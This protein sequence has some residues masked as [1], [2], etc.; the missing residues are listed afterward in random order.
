MDQA[1]EVVVEMTEGILAGI[2][3]DLADVAPEEADWRPLPEANSIGLIVRHLAIE[4]Q[5]HRACLERGEPMPHELTDEI[6]HQIDSVPLDF[7]QNRAMFEQALESFLARLRDTTLAG[8][9]ERSREAYG[10]RLRSPHVL[11]FHQALH[12]CMH[13]GQIRT[14]RNLYEKT[15]GRPARYFP[16]NPT[17]PRAG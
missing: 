8:L 15:R 12:V 16:E 3:E 4:A 9:A 10:E 13:W 17:Y 11:G 5:W 6:Q 1:L 2:R 7:A 14:I